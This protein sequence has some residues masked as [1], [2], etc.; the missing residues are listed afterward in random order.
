MNSIEN[1]LKI[2]KVTQFEPNDIIT[3]EGENSDSMFLILKGTAGV[4]KNYN[5]G[6]EKKL[7]ILKSGAFF[8]EMSLFLG[9]KRAATVVAESPTAILTI[10]RINARQVFAAEPE[11]TLFIMETLFERLNIVTSECAAKADKLG[12][13]PQPPAKEY[14]FK[15]NN[16]SGECLYSYKKG[17]ILSR[18]EAQNLYFILSGKAQLYFN[19]GKPE[20]FQLGGLAAGNYFGESIL[21]KIT[22]VAAEDTLIL[23]LNNRSA[24]KFFSNEPETTFRIIET[25]CDRLDLLYD[26]YESFF[27]DK[28]TTDGY[29]SHI[30]FPDGHKVYERGINRKCK[31]LYEKYHTCPICKKKF[32][33]AS[34][35]EKDLTIVSVDD[36]FRGHYEQIDPIHYE[37]LTCPKCWFSALEEYFSS[38]YYTR[39]IF[40]E[41]M[42]PYK[43]QMRFSFQQDINSVFTSYYL[44]SVCAAFCYTSNTPLV[45]GLTWQRIAWLYEDCREE[46]MRDMALRYSLNY[47]SSAYGTAVI[48][49]K[50]LHSTMI[51]I[52][53]QNYKLGRY[54]EALAFLDK[55]ANMKGI[56]ESNKLKAMELLKKYRNSRQND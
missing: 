15:V 19:Y 21:G 5:L 40:E 32:I 41:K 52:G 24:Y 31:Q 23:V 4:Y 43:F 14:T 10:E 8:G 33:A 45:M 29:R 51:V 18:G 11:I 47:L 16:P 39:S 38:A 49:A 48:P 26:Y 1:L 46:A 50:Q 22:A 54:H 30:L 27:A 42:E 37:V 17:E 25:A 20:A 56:S 44:A 55:T 53:V 35:R 13:P 36:D 6:T 12:V 3:E 7:D 2:A 28:L 34:V 9:S